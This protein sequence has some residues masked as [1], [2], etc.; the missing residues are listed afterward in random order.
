MDPLLVGEVLCEL[1][2]WTLEWADWLLVGDFFEKLTDG[3]VEMC[4]FDAN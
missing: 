3:E 2:E 1:V 4:E